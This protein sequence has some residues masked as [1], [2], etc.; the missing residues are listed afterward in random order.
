MSMLSRVHFE[1]IYPHGVPPESIMCLNS[2]EP[3]SQ[4]ELKTADWQ[5]LKVQIHF[6]CCLNINVGSVWTHPSYNDKNPPSVFLN[7]LSNQAVLRSLSQWRRSVQ[8]PPTIVD[9]QDRLTLDPPSVSGHPSAVVSTPVEGKTRMSQI[10]RLKCF[11]VGCSNKHSSY[12]L[13]PTSE[14]LKTQRINV[15]FVLKGMRWSRSA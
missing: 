6:T 13:L 2:P 5:Q 7:P 12:H 3:V 10:K 14:P 8:A 11:V 15:T 1:H 4:H 9:W